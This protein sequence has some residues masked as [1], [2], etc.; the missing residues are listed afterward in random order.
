MKKLISYF[1]I[2]H[3]NCSLNEIINTKLQLYKYSH[4]CS[5]FYELC[6]YVLVSSKMFLSKQ[7]STREQ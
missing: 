3:L 7:R 5:L 1:N 2:S 6:N 4:V